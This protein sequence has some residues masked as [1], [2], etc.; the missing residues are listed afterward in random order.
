MAEIT[1]R[2]DGIELDEPVLVEGLPGV[3][4]V[5]KI[6]T[7]HVV[8][9]LEMEYYASVKCDGLP[10][11]AVYEGG[12]RS[13]RPPVRIYADEENDLLALRSDV[14]IPKESFESFA[15]CVTGWIA[16]NDATPIYLSGLPAE[17]DGV[18]DLFGIATGDGGERLD[19]IDVPT[20]EARGAISG[21]TGALLARAGQL[22]LPSIGLIVESNKQ[23]PDPAAAQ[24]II[25]HGIEPLAAVDV[26][27]QQLVDR[28][29]EIQ[30]Q[31]EQLAARMQQAD[32][33][34]STQAQ[35]LRMFQ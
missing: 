19:G 2:D 23:F 31:R 8:D 7:D 24:V 3:G 27:V 10:R 28:A 6:A 12:E 15:S 17:R 9:A 18:P 33:E 4:L 14:P 11:I 5:G 1:V 34:E 20:P 16:N 32:E 22:D 35:P 30:E 26:G 13:V 29:E 21:P 25:E